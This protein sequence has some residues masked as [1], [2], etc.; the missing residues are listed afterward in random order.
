MTQKLITIITP[1]LNE[2]ENVTACHEAVMRVFQDSLPDYI[3]EHIFTDNAST[4]GTIEE[5]RQLASNF[6]EVK[7][8][9][10]SRDFGADASLL[11]AVCRSSGNA[12]VVM[13]PADLQDP[14]DL[15]P[16]FVR[17]WEDGSKVVFGIRR[18]RREN[19]ILAAMRKVFYRLANRM[20]EFPIPVDVGDFQLID[21]D[22]ARALS[23]FG[24]TRP[25]LR[26]MIAACGF[27]S[28]GI[29]Y[30]VRDRTRGKSTMS[31]MKLFRM[32]LNSL[33]AYSTLP[34]RASMAVG[35]FVA[36]ISLAYAVVSFITNAIFFPLAPP[37]IPT[38][39][40]AMF[41]FGGL[42]LFFL[43]VLGEYVLAIHSQVRGRP[44]TIEA[45]L[46]NFGTADSPPSK[47]GPPR[48]DNADRS[49]GRVIGPRPSS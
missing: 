32:A 17:L 21:R 40:V 6:P 16:E 29:E 20:S 13:I 10:N 43:G 19:W 35:F 33:T 22:V 45:E 15:I 18:G 38:L 42:Q 30:N 23:R 31:M 41:A 4:D 44:L 9:L 34:M 28:T 48:A 7:V 14:P 26:G 27:P 46:I 12:V 24:D 39:I 3:H 47:D 5:L 37:G 1:T 36:G 25:F 49:S 8:I 11:N 2:R